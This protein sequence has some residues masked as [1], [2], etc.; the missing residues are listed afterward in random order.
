[1]LLNNISKIE[2]R[3]EKIYIF[4]QGIQ[5]ENYPVALLNQKLKLR[6]GY[7]PFLQSISQTFKFIS[8]DC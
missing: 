1:M 8:N 4:F 2:F 3:C 5:D 6:Y 7:L